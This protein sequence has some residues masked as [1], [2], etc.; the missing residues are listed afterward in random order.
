MVEVLL[1]S[2]SGVGESPGLR[3][4]ALLEADSAGVGA[5]VLRV[6]LPADDRM[7]ARR[8]QTRGYLPLEETGTP[9]GRALVH[10][11]RLRPLPVPGLAVSFLESM[12]ESF[13]DAVRATLLFV[14]RGRRILL[15]HKKR[16]HGAGNINGPGGKLDPGETP[17]QCAIREVEEELRIRVTPPRFVGELLFQETD[18]SRIHGYVFRSGGYRGTPTETEEAI[19]LWCDIDAIPGTGCGGTI[20]SGCPGCWKESSSAPLS[21]ATVRASSRRCSSRAR[22]PSRTEPLQPSPLR[23][24]P[25]IAR[26]C[27]DGAKKQ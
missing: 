20:V 18:G 23:H 25:A 11:K 17:R 27:P 8:W 15:I 9:A 2:G 7:L 21:S 13:P 22:S 3:L 19:P 14:V 4:L 10:D 12:P 16:G 26:T 5:G 24:F 6:R 1:E